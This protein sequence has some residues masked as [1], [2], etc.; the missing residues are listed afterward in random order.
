METDQGIWERVLSGEGGAFGE[1]WDRHRDR[2]LRHA[3]RLLDNHSDAEDAT[4]MAFLELWRRRV[5]ARVVEGSVLPWL[6]VVTTN[7]VRNI[8]RARRRYRD[9]LAR[10]PEPATS[11]DAGELV[12]S[13]ADAV[14]RLA[15]FA[16]LGLTDQHLITLVA[17]DELSVRDAATALGLSYGAAKTRLSRAR[18]RLEAAHD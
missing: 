8:T 11:R 3:Q 17:F 5:D 12:A 6:L 10:L 18:A 15:G 14:E 1:L 2:V 9:V 4:A 13:R 7:V 16:R